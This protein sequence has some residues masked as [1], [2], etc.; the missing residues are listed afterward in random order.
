M[1]LF[2]ECSIIFLNTY[3]DKG[4]YVMVKV[5]QTVQYNDE[6]VEELLYLLKTKK[7]EKRRISCYY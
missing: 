3:L 5:T 7:R 1:Q 2:T 6:L 4:I